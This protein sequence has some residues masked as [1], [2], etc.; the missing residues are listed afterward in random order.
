[1]ANL[2][3]ARNTKRLVCADNATFDG[4]MGTDETV[5][6]G[7]MVGIDAAGDIIKGGGASANFS[8]AILG[9]A[10]Q[11]IESATGGEIVEF[12]QGIF[13]YGIGGTVDRTLV[14]QIV[15]A[16]DDQTITDVDTNVVAGVLVKIEGDQAYV[17][18]GFYNF[19]APA[20]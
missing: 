8:A 10:S 16:A 5:Y 2:T 6:K 12:E 13:G 17:K 11:T 20:P 4:V 9:R 19:L 14:G 15:Y 18:L 3:E 1:M 7:G